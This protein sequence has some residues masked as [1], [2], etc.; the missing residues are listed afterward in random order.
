MTTAL[1]IANA[2]NRIAQ[3]GVGYDKQSA[4][5]KAILHGQ[6]ISVAASVGGSYN[7]QTGV[8]SFPTP[9]DAHA[10]TVT[11]KPSVV[12]T[13]GQNSIT[14]TPTGIVSGS[15][16]A[17]LSD[18]ESRRAYANSLVYSN[19][20][21]IAAIQ[22]KSSDIYVQTGRWDTPEQIAY[23]NQAEQMRVALNPTYT[24]SAWGPTTQAAENN[25]ILPTNQFP[26]S[27]I[28]QNGASSLLK[29]TVTGA[30]TNGLIGM[31]AGLGFLFVLFSL[32]RGRH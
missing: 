12:T 11:Q 20:P 31:A 2:Q 9:S 23:H 27:D 7:S 14:S 8:W 25:L 1:E 26:T 4:A 3:I 21:A 13:A 17:L 29:S 18:I 16:S 5:D 28:L 10:D 15:T 19:D 22:R 32:F 24:G 30:N 6:A